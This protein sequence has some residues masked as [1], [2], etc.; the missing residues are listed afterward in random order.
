MIKKLIVTYTLKA[1]FAFFI[2]DIDCWT[3]WRSLI[4]EIVEKCSYFHFQYNW[5][6]I[7]FRSNHVF[8]CKM[9]DQLTMVLLKCIEKWCYSTFILSIMVTQFWGNLCDKRII[10]FSI[11]ISLLL[12]TRTQN[13]I[14]IWVESIN[15]DF[16]Y[17]PRQANFQ[18]TLMSILTSWDP[19]ISEI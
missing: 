19:R 3:A 13:L 1:C 5:S 8:G 7:Q 12:R 16:S 15:L 17:R 11:Q 2:P 18:G 10:H 4:S 9:A 14:D 6:I